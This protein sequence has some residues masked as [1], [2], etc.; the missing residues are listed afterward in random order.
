MIT[1]G[2]LADAHFRLCILSTD[3]HGL[4][5]KIHSLPFAQ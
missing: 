5:A 1:V 4:Q 3:V 2:I